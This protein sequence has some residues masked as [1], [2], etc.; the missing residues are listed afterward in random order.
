MRLL[1]SAVAVVCVIAGALG[2]AQAVRMLRGEI[3]GVTAERRLAKGHPARAIGRARDAINRQGRTYRQV[4][5]LA[6]IEEALGRPRK[7]RA[8]WNE[9]LELRPSWPYAWAQR[10]RAELQHDTDPDSLQT[11]LERSAE[12][13][14]EER[15]LWRFYATQAL[16][17]STKPLP[18]P[19]RRFLELRVEREFALHPTQLMGH[20]LRRRQE[21]AL[22]EIVMRSQ[23]E[24]Y[25]CRAASY[26]RPICDQAGLTREQ[27]RWCDD[28]QQLWRQFD[29][30]AS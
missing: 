17:H 1:V 25:W 15:G 29:Y 21:P 20:A 28:L 30:A 24:P 26:A 11:L 22:C 3:V 7:A 4:E 23:E 9:A 16:A 10:A 8:F 12:L 6:R 18:D 5:R 14:D 27:T 2:A 19:A 13:G